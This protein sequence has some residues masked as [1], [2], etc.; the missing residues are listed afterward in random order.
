MYSLRAQEK[1][2]S[3]MGVWNS[4]REKRMSEK[5][6]I[7][8]NKTPSKTNTSKYRTACQELEEI[9]NSEQQK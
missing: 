6:T 4:R 3:P 9:Y 8:R 1:T 5:M 7:S 2:K